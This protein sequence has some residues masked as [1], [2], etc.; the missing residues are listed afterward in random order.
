MANILPAA[1][2]VYLRFL[3]HR[4]GNILARP[5]REMNRNMAGFTKSFLT[6]KEFSALTGLSPSTIRRLVHEG[7]LPCLQ[8]GGRKHRLLFEADALCCAT[9]AC[10]KPQDGTQS[11]Q[12]D[13]AHP[14]AQMSPALTTPVHTKDGGPGPRWKRNLAA[15]QM[16]PWNLKD[17]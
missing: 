13:L 10:R 1:S 4:A 2:G 8:P 5:H 15:L 3:S 9:N 12:A 16:L 14:A 11:S 7:L 6:L 17:K